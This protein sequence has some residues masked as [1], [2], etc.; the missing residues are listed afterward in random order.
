M[1]DIDENIERVMNVSSGLL[2]SIDS[3]DKANLVDPQGGGTYK[4]FIRALKPRWMV[5]WCE[6]L[7]GHLVLI[8][9]IF[10]II[11]FEALTSLLPLTIVLG[12]LIFGFTHAYIQLFFHEAAHGNIAKNRKFNDFL[13][14]ILI[15]IF[16]GQDIKAYRLIH[17]KH[18]L[19]LGTTE[20][21]ERA[22]F[23]Q[24]NMRF[25]IESLTG[26]RAMKVLFDRKNLS[27]ASFKV[28]TTTKKNRI[29]KY[30]VIGILLH[31]AI[32]GVAIG[33]GH[34]AMALAWCIG[35]GVL[36]PFFGAV[37]PVLEHRDLSAKSQLDYRTV[38]HGP[39]HRLFGDSL[40]ARTLG[41]AGFNRH[42]L[43]HWE[44]QISYTQL[45]A[46]EKFLLQTI[47][48]DL[49]CSHQTT[50]AATFMRLMRTS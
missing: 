28:G 33:L 38:P 11:K 43:H 3:L 48:A 14:N 8:A 19:K 26:I 36:M 4:E 22:Y 6:L 7:A 10:G 49:I 25:I 37:R 31:L 2:V 50:Y 16:V 47:A 15:G 41:G 24:L 45:R 35:I 17:F 5:L 23:D 1:D 42:L 27:R 44:P 32:L 20:D 21:P 34:W 39:I 46:L 30:L 12:A 9:T 40:L 18:H 13:A 29:N